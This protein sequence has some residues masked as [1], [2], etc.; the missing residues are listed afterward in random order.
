MTR[1]MLNQRERTFIFP[2]AFMKVPLARVRGNFRGSASLG[3][4]EEE[5][6]MVVDFSRFSAMALGYIGIWVR[7]LMSQ[8]IADTLDENKELPIHAI[9][10][11]FQVMMFSDAIGKLADIT[12]P[13]PG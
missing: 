12:G 7:M 5:H 8:I 4:R 9:A 6:K 3:E 13:T 1:G 2:N 11:L 10:E